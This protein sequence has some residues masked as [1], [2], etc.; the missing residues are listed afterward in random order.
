MPANPRVL[1]RRTPAPPSPHREPAVMDRLS[2]CPW[3]LAVALAACTQGSDPADL[4][5][6][7]G[8]A[9]QSI[10]V[11]DFGRWECNRPIEFVFDRPIDFASVSDRSVRIRT[12]GG[13]PAA[14]TYTAKAIDADDDGVPEG[15][16]ERVIVF[17]PRCP[18]AA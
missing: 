8:F 9:V 11:P 16:D 12:S 2:T 1:G 14:G 10:S 5:D 13:V 17:V 3:V 4:P 18:Q 15:T 6:P 7:S